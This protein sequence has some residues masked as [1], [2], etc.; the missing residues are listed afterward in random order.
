MVIF[1][2][3]CGHIDTKKH[4]RMTLVWST[5]QC[6]TQK[7]VI[8]QLKEKYTKKVCYDKHTDINSQTDTPLLPF[9]T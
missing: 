9:Y 2:F 1:A 3:F 6:H 5:I 8:C 4:F 7:N